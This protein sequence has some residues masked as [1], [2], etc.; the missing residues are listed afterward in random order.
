MWEERAKNKN[1]EDTKRETKQRKNRD[2]NKYKLTNV[3]AFSFVRFSM[4]VITECL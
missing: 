2:E 1:K 3:K 4:F